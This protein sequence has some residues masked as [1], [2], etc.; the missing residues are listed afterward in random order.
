MSESNNLVLIDKGLL[1][2]VKNILE[3]SGKIEIANEL[4]SG[5]IEFD[6]NKIKAE[7][8]LEYAKLKGVADCEAI[9]YANKLE[10]GEL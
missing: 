5:C 6:E 2:L 4:K 9:N 10:R 3:R 8:V 7:A 1:S